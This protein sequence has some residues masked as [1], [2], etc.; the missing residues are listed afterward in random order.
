MPDPIPMALLGRLAVDVPERG[1]GLGASLLQDAVIRVARAADLLAVKGIL[2]DAI[3]DDAQKFYVHF[4][5]RPS[6]VSPLKLMVL[7]DE[8]VKRMA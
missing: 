3:D 7:L 1:T 4:G 5:I 8:V 2:V 6:P